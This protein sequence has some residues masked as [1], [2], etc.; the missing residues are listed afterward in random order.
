LGLL[1]KDIRV[2][3]K[4]PFSVFTSGEIDEKRFSGLLWEA[5]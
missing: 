1:K 5:K 2:T 4:S 3:E